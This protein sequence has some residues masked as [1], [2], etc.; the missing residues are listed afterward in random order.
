MRPWWPPECI[1][2]VWRIRTLRVSKPAAWHLDSD[3]RKIGIQE[4]GPDRNR[5]LHRPTPN[6]RPTV[7]CRRCEARGGDGEPDPARHRNQRARQTLTPRMY[8]TLPL[9]SGG[10]QN[11]SAF[12]GYMAGVNA[13]RGDQHRRIHRP[14]ARTTDR[15]HQQRDSRVRRYSVQSSLSRGFQ[16]VQAAGWHLYR[17]IRARRRWNRNLHHAVRH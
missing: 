17:R 9:W 14:G 3:C 15:R 7:G 2:G 16:R 10:L 5:N 13:C 6:T 1:H 11:P 12:L 4:V 8:Q